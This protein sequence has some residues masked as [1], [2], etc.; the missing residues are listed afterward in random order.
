MKVCC[1]VM[2]LV[3]LAGCDPVQWPADV[4]LPDGAVYDGETRDDLF[5]GEGTLTW[6][7]GRYYEGAFREGRLHGHGKLVDR[8]GCVQEGQ[9]VDGVLHGQGQFTCDEATWQGRFEQGELVE[10]SVS[11]TEGGSYQ[12]E[13]RDLAPHGQGLWVTEAGQHYEGRF[14][15]GELVEGRYRDEEGY[16]YEGQFRYFSFH[17]QGTLTRPDGVV[18]RGEFENG[19]AHGNGTRT[20]PA[21]G[22]AQAQVEKGYF[23]R[24]RY[25]ASEEAYQKNRHA[26]AAQIEAR[27]YTESSRLQSVL[28]SLAP[29]R[30]G[31]RDVYLL[32]VGGDGTEGVF[33]REV[34]W[35]AERLGSVFDL[36]RRHVKLVNGGSDDLPLATRTSVREALEALD[37]LMDPNED[38]L[39]V[40]LVSHGSREGALLLDDHNLTLNDL[41]V[42]D[43]KQWLNALKARHQW[44]VVSACYSGQWVDA[45]ASPRRVIFASAASD[46]TSFGCGDDSD[47]TW[48]SKALYGEDMAAGID[49]PAAWFAATS[50]KV[51]GMEEEQGIDGEEHSMP[52]QAVGEAFVRWWQGNKAVNS[53]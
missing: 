51:T 39:M 29:Q 3:A 47:R 10:G 43:G 31:V 4:R 23:V 15:N 38:L 52:Q 40:H 1:L 42:A 49:D 41:S 36:K 30:P 25:Y 11:Y 19:Y 12:G 24:G 37:A 48:F 7:D 6:P 16:Q 33:A 20:R 13:F 9:F 26:Q 46:R 32:V 21:E 5:H 14:E 34:D 50:V 22:D 27:L 8:R 28:S 53:E 18:I 45:L 44:L 2:V 35:V 17:G